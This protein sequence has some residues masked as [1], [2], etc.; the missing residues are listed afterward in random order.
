MDVRIKFLGG[1]QTVTGSKFLL[2]VG[3]YKVMVDC[4][5]FQGP[6][7]HRVRN[8][9]W[10][11]VDFFKIDGVVLTHAHLDHSGYLPRLYRSGYQ[12]SI[13]CTQATA[14]LLEILLKDSAKLNIEEA[15]FA[16]K[17]GYS[18]HQFPRP[19]YDMDDVNDTL[20]HIKNIPFDEAYILQAGINVSF[21]KAGHILGAAS[22][23]FQIEGDHQRKRILFS[24]D[25]GRYNQPLMPDPTPFEETDI[26]FIESTYGGRSHPDGDPKEAFKEIINRTTSR[27]GSVIIPSFALGRTQNLLYY[28]RELFLDNTIDDIPVFVDSPMAINVTHLYQEYDHLHKLNTE[29]G[30]P[31]IFSHP[32]FHYVTSQT[33]STA[34]N[35]R[36]GPCIIISA[37]GMCTGGRILHH[38]YHRL[39]REQ[40]S[41]FFVGYQAQGTR[42]HRLLSGEKKIKIFGEQ[43]EVHCEIAEFQGLSAHADHNELLRWLSNFKKAPKQTFI[44]HGERD[45]SVALATAIRETLNWSNVTIPSFLQSFHLFEGI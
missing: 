26:L 14:E 41:V 38:L 11:P 34:L 22:L 37:S 1:A 28:L 44:I 32:N 25:L 6:K 35:E 33:E 8:W 40:D 43:V 5:L 12:G 16:R 13:Y 7:E 21:H 15:I 20:P 36:K 31:D 23:M 10:L 19:L 24:G 2:E 30:A 39:S 42:G 18:R 29:E 45:S 4:G 27:G 9:E 3:S 17:K